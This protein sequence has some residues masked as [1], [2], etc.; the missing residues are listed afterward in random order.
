MIVTGGATGIGRAA[1][2]RLIAEGASVAVLTLDGEGGPGDRLT[3]A[4][5]V[6]DAGSVDEAVNRAAGVFGRIDG[7][8]NSAGI[9]NTVG[10]DPGGEP[11]EHF[12]RILRVNVGGM[13][14]AARAA[15]PHLARRGGCVV[16]VGSVMG[17]G[18]YPGFPGYTA[19]KAAVEGLTRALALDGA[20]QGIR[21]V[22][23]L[24]GAID[25]PMQDRAVAA[26]D[27]RA[28]HRA[29]T[30]AGI[31]LNRMGTPAEVANMIAFLMSDEASWVTGGA[32]V[33]DGGADARGP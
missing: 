24:P 9:M 15:W 22:A 2:D 3:L 10:F 26:S 8:V 12:D 14:N 13:M 32:Y 5:D 27:D 6:A 31:P 21:C 30:L 1:A 20:E 17:R 18:T 28:E 16:N 25:T 19:S 23:V 4:C 33:V 7:V 11:A 29:K